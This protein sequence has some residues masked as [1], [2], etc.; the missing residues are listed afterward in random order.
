MGRS[1]AKRGFKRNPQSPSP[2]SVDHGPD[3]AG[4]KLCG[5]IVPDLTQ[6][7]VIF[8]NIKHL[9]PYDVIPDRFRNRSDP[10]VKFVAEWFF[11]GRTQEDMRRLKTRASVERGKALAAIKCVLGSFEPR[12]EHKEA[13][14]AFMLHEWFELS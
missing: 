12:H 9:P 14:C 5:K 11:Q 13:G 6:V 1:R 10:Y 4:L 3:E 7:D 8:G 2:P